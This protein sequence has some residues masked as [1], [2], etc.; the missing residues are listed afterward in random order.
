[1]AL[2]TMRPAIVARDLR[3][4]QL[5]TR[6]ETD[7]F[8]LSPEW[9]DLCQF[10]KETRWPALIIK[11]GHCC[12]DPHCKA[13]HRLGQRIFFDH[14]VELR[15]GGDPLDPDNVQGLCGSAHT[16]KTVAARVARLG[17]SVDGEGGSK[18]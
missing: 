2:S 14:I 15:D 5:P 4:V 9:R 6:K 10:L 11:Q 7:P 18:L 17:A 1:M 16:R 3:R 13:R 12:E 8:Y